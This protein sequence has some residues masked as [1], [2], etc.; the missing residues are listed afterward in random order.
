M[1]EQT[2]KSEICTNVF[3]NGSPCTTVELFTQRWVELINRLEREK[4]QAATKK[5]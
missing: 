2:I 4:E 3:Q 5:Q 1:S